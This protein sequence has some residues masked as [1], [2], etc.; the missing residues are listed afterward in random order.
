MVSTTSFE[1]EHVVD[2]QLQE[3][4]LIVA[5]D[6]P[7]DVHGDE[8][9]LGIE[10]IQAEAEDADDLERSRPGEHAERRHASRAG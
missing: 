6:A 5:E 3:D 8:A 1:L 10:L 4:R 9:V 2:A 7:G